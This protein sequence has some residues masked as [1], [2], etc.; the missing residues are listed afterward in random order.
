MEV[1]SNMD[2]KKSRLRSTENIPNNELIDSNE[3]NNATPE[4]TQ[5]IES[6]LGQMPQ[7]LLIRALDDKHHK[8]VCM[9]QKT[10][11][12]YS[13]P[14]P[15]P[16]MLADYDQIKQGFAERIFSMAENEQKHRHELENLSVNGHINKDKRS[17]RYALFCVVFITTVCGVIIYT[18]NSIAGTLLGGSTILGLAAL[19]ITGKSDNKKTTADENDKNDKNDKNDENEGNEENEENEEN[20]K[21]DENDETIK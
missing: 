13:G 18:G 8:I 17:Q 19:F 11:Q 4:N 9:T 14:L 7:E 16:S 5:Q 6:L 10:S 2:K 3:I 21:N 12:A 20:D 15:P 1:Y